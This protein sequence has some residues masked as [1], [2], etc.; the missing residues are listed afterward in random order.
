MKCGAF[1]RL[2]SPSEIEEK[3]Y[4]LKEKSFSCCHLVYKPEKYTIEDACVIKN[5][6]EKIGV[7]ISA[8][9]AGFRD[10]Y[11]KWNL[12][13]DFKDAG[14]N[15]KKYGK[16]R[17]EYLKQAATFASNVG[18]KNMLIHAGFVENNPFS[19]EYLRMVKLVRALSEHLK[20][21]GLNLLLETGGES[22]IV[23]KRLIEDVGT[24]NVFANLDTA[25]LIMYG[26]GNPTDA[27]YTLG[28]Y[29]KSVHIKDGTP[30]TDTRNL[31]KECEFGEG[32]VD[33]P[34]VIS[35]LMENSFDGPYIIEREIA[36]GTSEIKINETLEKLSGLVSSA[37]PIT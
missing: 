36:D 10:N 17:I 32:F 28:S 18:T 5:A 24:G 26:F 30:P 29:I 37:K 25:N 14:I 11:T 3:L 7:E 19:S 21:L 15:S 8:L 6:A 13:S 22:P 35:L 31:G 27:A 33:F 12:Y 23:L 20:S 2:K 9:F 16:K 1:L 4:A 34:R